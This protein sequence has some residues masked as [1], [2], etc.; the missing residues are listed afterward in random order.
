MASSEVLRTEHTLIQQPHPLLNSFYVPGRFG[1]SGGA[2]GGGGGV[3]LYLCITLILVTALLCFWVRTYRLRSLG[4]HCNRAK[5]ESRLVPNRD[6]EL[7]ECWFKE[8]RDPASVT[9]T[10]DT[11][12]NGEEGAFTQRKQPEAYWRERQE[13]WGLYKEEHFGQVQEICGRL[14]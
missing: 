2:G 1:G 5:P 7:P 3:V 6:S 14:S 4:T 12:G 13:S 10:Q 9:W 8:A 11:R